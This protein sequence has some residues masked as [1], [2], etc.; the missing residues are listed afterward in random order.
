MAARG[1]PLRI[2][3]ADAARG[4]C[5]QDGGKMAHGSAPNHDIYHDKANMMIIIKPVKGQGSG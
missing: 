2:D 1:E 4:S 3:L 5:D